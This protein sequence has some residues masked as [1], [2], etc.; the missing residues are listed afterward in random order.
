MCFH[1]TCLFHSER[2]H[3]TTL[4]S[5]HF[6]KHKT[7]AMLTWVNNVA[8][9]RVSNSCILKPAFAL[10]V[11]NMNW[12]EDQCRSMF[13]KVLKPPLDFWQACITFHIVLQY[14]SEYYFHQ[15]V[16][17]RLLRTV[18]HP[19]TTHV[20]KYHGLHCTAVCW[21]PNAWVPKSFC[22]D[23]SHLGWKEDSRVKRNR[24]VG[25]SRLRWAVP[26]PQSTMYGAAHIAIV[27][28]IPVAFRAG[29]SRPLH[30]FPSTSPGKDNNKY[31][32]LLHYSSLSCS[33]VAK[34]ESSK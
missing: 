10:Y 18:Q 2:P 7:P 22:P 17:R 5:S 3:C 30:L 4:I 11:L 32:W 28:G 9:P 26:I 1:P 21:S 20:R 15:S 31:S 27:I 25:I 6:E 13:H 8:Y 19:V 12:F 23:F 34:L 29:S 16:L 33:L 24:K 14:S